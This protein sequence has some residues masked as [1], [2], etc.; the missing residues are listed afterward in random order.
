MDNCTISAKALLGLLQIKFTEDFI[1]DCIQS[2]PDHPS[3]LCISN[4]L[5]RYGVENLALKV[6]ETKLAQL[7]LPCIVQ[8]SDHG[9]LFRV[10]TGFSGDKAIYVG[11]RGK[12]IKLPKEEFLDRWSGVCLVAETNESSGEPGIEKR[13]RDKRTMSILT[14]SA[15]VLILITIVIMMAKSPVMIG[16]N[17]FFLGAYVLLKLVGLAMGT[18]LLWYEVDKY[19]P[20][21]QSFCSG[22]KKIDCDAVLGSKYAKV[23]N[24]NLSL[25]L[26]VFSYFFGTLSYLTITSFTSNSLLTLALLSSAALPLVMFSAYYQGVVIKQWCKFCFVVQGVLVLEM[27]TAFFGGFYETGMTWETQPLLFALLLIPIIA[28][29]VLKPLLETKKETVLYK[30]GLKKI[31]NNPDVLQGLLA[32]TR[33]ITAGTE[34]LGIS[35]NNKYAKYNVVKV[36][37]PYCGPCAKAHPV[38]EELVSKGKINLQVL[39]TAHTDEKDLKRKP[40]SHFLALDAHGDKGRVHEAL[41]D[42]YNAGKMDYNIFA[43]KYPLNGELEEQNTK[44]AAMRQWCDIENITHTPTIFINGHELPKEYSVEDLKEV[45]I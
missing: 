18:M 38:L 15:A 11:D 7:P 12:P 14:S 2:H 29:N 19:N 1:E 6:D 9:G 36:C 5:D 17:G 42:W 23:F 35:L 4:T 31:K 43:N 20:T 30:R 44:I 16:Y 34:G 8:L 26:V 32:K 40:V 39:F 33:K 13:L 28:W 25:N 24:G 41:D 3:L 27:M 22:G 21:L 37:N 10:L 45:L